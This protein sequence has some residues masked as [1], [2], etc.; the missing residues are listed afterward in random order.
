MKRIIGRILWS[1]SIIV[2]SPLI[3]LG[4]VFIVWSKE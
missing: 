3:L 2:F 4:L 1:L